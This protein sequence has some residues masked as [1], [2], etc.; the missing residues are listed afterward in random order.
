MAR[1]PSSARSS[2]TSTSSST[3]SSSRSAASR[4]SR[5]GKVDIYCPQ[6]AAHYRIP[7]TSL[8]SKVT[9]NEC[10]RTFFAKTTAGKRPRAKDNS[11]VYLGFGIGALVIIVGLVMLSSGGNEKPRQTNTVKT[12]T[13]T[14]LQR[15]KELRRGQLLKWAEFAGRG[16]MYGLGQY[17]DLP[18]LATALGMTSKV[19]DSGFDD[20]FTASLKANEVTR[21]LHEMIPASVD[22]SDSA[23]EANG[24]EGIVFLRSKPGDTV[25]DSKAGGSIVIDW[26]YTSG[27]VR[28]SGFRIGTPPVVRGRRPGDVTA[29][30]FVPSADVAKPEVKVI[31]FAGEKIKV[32]ESP[33][34]PLGHMAET[35]AALQKEVDALVARL[36]T[37]ADS[38]M[39]AEANK[40]RMAIARLQLPDRED[41]NPA[42][43][44]LLNA[45][46]DLYGDVMG[47]NQKILQVTRSLLDC[48]GMQFAY[49]FRGEGDPQVV[50]AKRESVIRQWFAWWYRYANDTHQAAID[51]VE[52]LDAPSS[53][54]SGGGR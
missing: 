6:C 29:T 32:N 28:V 50:K 19:G 49:D 25:Y 26:I 14:K 13:T 33:P 40:A 23:V 36:L 42:I 31:D 15:E 35:P 39:P 41:R 5:D 44:R 34:V 47:N 20:E 16:E 53:K 1:R 12:D 43:P 2:R 46:H 22:V 54:E 11:K 51:P 18:K 4:P 8:D 10:Q 24:G 7:E 27:S 3:R 30:T 45:L 21:L 52:D 38:D 37:S 17:S 48:T 9:C